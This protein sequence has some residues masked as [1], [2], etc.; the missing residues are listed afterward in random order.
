MTSS[1]CIKQEDFPAMN[2]HLSKAR[3]VEPRLGILLQPVWGARSG[4]GFAQLMA[5][6]IWRASEMVLITASFHFCLFLLGSKSKLNLLIS[7]ILQNS[8]DSRLQLHE[9]ARN[10]K[11]DIFCPVWVFLQVDEASERRA[12]TFAQQG[13][14]MAEAGVSLNGACLEIWGVLT[15]NVKIIR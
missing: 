3:G 2:L 4:W 7:R 6:G 10:D 1:W 15:N 5:I 11:P 13:L 14:R 9:T 12:P 8:P